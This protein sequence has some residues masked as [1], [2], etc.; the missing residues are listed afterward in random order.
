MSHCL[1]DLCD[2]CDGYDVYDVYE[3]TCT[4]PTVYLTPN[5]TKNVLALSDNN[6]SHADLSCLFR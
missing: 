2:L 5:N 6:I 1:C 3:V 4:I